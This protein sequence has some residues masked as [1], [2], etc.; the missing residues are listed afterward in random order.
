M[1]TRRNFSRL[2]TYVFVVLL[3]EADH[4]THPSQQLKTNK[5]KSFEQGRAHKAAKD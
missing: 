5:L 3:H 1:E 2:I 4:S